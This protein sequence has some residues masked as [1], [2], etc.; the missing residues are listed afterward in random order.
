MKNT[1]IGGGS[2]REFD[3]VV[4]NLQEYQ[5]SIWLDFDHFPDSHLEFEVG[6]AEDKSQVM[7]DIEK[8]SGSDGRSD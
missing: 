2:V 8:M 4:L 3:A 5:D 1:V 6:A 7:G